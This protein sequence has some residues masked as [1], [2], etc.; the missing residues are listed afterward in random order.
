LDLLKLRAC[1][2]GLALCVPWAPTYHYLFPTCIKSAIETLLILAL[3]KEFSQLHA[4]NNTKSNSSSNDTNSSSS[5]SSSIE[6]I[7]SSTARLLQGTNSRVV[8]LVCFPESIVHRLPP[9]IWFMIFEMLVEVSAEATEP[10]QTLHVQHQTNSATDSSDGVEDEDGE[11][12]GSPRN[13]LQQQQQQ[14]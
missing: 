5:S 8:Q 10:P 1:V 4:I 7:N 6:I 3:R 13:N 12:N 9:E 11:Q 2:I 14:L